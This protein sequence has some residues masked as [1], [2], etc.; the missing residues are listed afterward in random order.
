MNLF[1]DTVKYTHLIVMIA[2]VVAPFTNDPYVL[3]MYHLFVP[4]WLVHLAVN[5]NMC[6]LTLT[7]QLLRGEVDRKK[8]F[9]GQVM[10]KVYKQPSEYIEKLTT[11]FIFALW[12]MVCLKLKFISLE[13]FRK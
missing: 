8:T 3:R 6:A 1:A 13:N 7:E 5:E 10:G 4:M 12:V 11:V 2:M 9:F